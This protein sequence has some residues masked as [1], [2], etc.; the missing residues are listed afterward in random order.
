MRTIALALCL[1]ACSAPVPGPRPLSVTGHLE[2]SPELSDVTWRASERWTEATYGWVSLTP[3]PGL[4]VR[5]GSCPNGSAACWLPK[6]PAIHVTPGLL[7][8][9]DAFLECAIIHE[10]GHAFGL[11]HSTERSS[12]MW[13]ELNVPCTITPADVENLYELD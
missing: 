7:A 12:V 2:P 5:R 10:L 11:G 13:P 8:R 6:I 1:A 9:P 4:P 3:G